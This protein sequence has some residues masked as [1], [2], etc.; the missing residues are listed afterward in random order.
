MG[1]EH[2]KLALQSGQHKAILRLEREGS[3][4][5]MQP[6]TPVCQTPPALLALFSGTQPEQ[7]NVWG[8]Y[9]PHPHRI[10][11]SLSG[12]HADVGNIRTVWQE[13]EERG[14][15]YSL[16]NVAFRNDPV[17]KEQSN[18]LVFGFDGYR[19]WKKPSFFRL[20]SGKRRLLYSG[21][22]LR[23][24]ATRREVV[25]SKGASFQTRIPVGAG[26]LVSLT[27]NTLA[28]VHTL[29]PGLLLVNP[30]N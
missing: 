24:Y 8:Y 20:R 10:E 23:A 3:V 15:G 9:M 2:W 12:F 19:L 25:L 29:K 21:L 27:P 17:W 4:F 22:D 30:L 1:F 7:N 13:M 16:M 26:K 14:K 18:Y 5:S 28:F 11:D 6:A